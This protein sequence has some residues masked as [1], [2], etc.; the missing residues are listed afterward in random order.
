VLPLDGAALR[1]VELEAHG[2][3]NSYQPRA[4]QPRW[5]AA[6]QARASSIPGVPTSSVL[7]LAHRRARL[8]R[9]KFHPAGGS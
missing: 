9:L 2:V 3:Y 6:T 8:L 1:F 5:G 4:P 7:K